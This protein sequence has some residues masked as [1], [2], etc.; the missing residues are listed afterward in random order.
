MHLE[1]YKMMADFV[2]K[3]LGDKVNEKLDI[4]DVGSQDVNGSYKKL[5]A[6]SLW[7]YIGCDMVPG[8]NVNVVLSNIY[9]WKEFEKDSKDVII[10]GQVFEH[11]EYFWNTMMEL[12]RVLKEDGIGCIIAPALIFEHR[13]PIDCWRFFSDGFKT[14]AKFAGVKVLECNTGW[15]TP[16]FYGNVDSILVFKKVKL[17][18]DEKE[19]QDSKIKL[20]KS[21]AIDYEIILPNV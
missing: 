4:L 21:L 3:Y 9:D 17:S 12:V 20:V 6:G 19:K 13:Y 5:F 8:K 10:T 16:G 18:K 2:V 7:N 14:L 1:S 11:V 15:A